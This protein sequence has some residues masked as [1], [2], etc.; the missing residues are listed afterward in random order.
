MI[1]TANG[2]RLDSTAYYP[3]KARGLQ[4][5]LLRGNAGFPASLFVGLRK[6][7]GVQ[8]VLW[9]RAFRQRESDDG[10]SDKGK[11]RQS[12]EA[13]Y[14]VGSRGLNRWLA[15]ARIAYEPDGL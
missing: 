9:V 6:W 2:G 14:V 7:R 4:R 8:V 15:F 11:C 10:G 3:E 1:H 12:G 13:G 5:N